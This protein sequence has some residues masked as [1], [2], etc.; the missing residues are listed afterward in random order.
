[1]VGFNPRYHPPCAGSASGDR[2][3]ACRSCGARAHSLA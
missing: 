1:M 3:R 2:P